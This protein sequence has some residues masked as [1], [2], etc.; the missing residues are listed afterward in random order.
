MK[1]FTIFLLF[2]FGGQVFS[3]KYQFKYFVQN[4]FVNDNIKEPGILTSFFANRDNNSI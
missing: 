4:R 3:Q 2:F 1:I